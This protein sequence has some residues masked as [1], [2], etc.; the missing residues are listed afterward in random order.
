MILEYES[1][2]TEDQKDP[3]KPFFLTVKQAAQNNP[4]GERYWYTNGRMGIN[5]LSQLFKSAFV[6]A[7]IDTGAAKILGTSG[8]KTMAQ[9]G[10]DS[11]VPGSFLSK[12][13]GQKNVDSKLEYIK[14]KENTHKA[15][16]LCIQRKMTGQSENECFDDVYRQVLAPTS[17][18]ESGMN[19]TAKSAAQGVGSNAESS[20]QGAR[21]TQHKDLN[22]PPSFQPTGPNLP[23]YGNHPSP[24]PLLSHPPPANYPPSTYYPQPANYPPPAYYPPTANYP[25]PPQPNVSLPYLTNFQHQLYASR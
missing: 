6:K 17:E 25:P 15:A 5:T 16:S 12:M 8:R 19:S 9:S 22:I 24:Q 11:L 21:S 23:P 18:K 7:N 13:M 10:A 3:E 4:E 20:G 2:K 14:N 1:K